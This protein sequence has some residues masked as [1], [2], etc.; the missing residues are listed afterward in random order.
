METILMGAMELLAAQGLKFTMDDLAKH[1]RMS[2]RTL[3]EKVGGKEHLLQLCMEEYFT[4]VKQL[5]QEILNEASTNGF[6][7]LK[8]LVV[9][10]PAMGK[11]LHISQLS[12]LKDTYPVLYEEVVYRVDHDWNATYDLLDEAIAQK[13]VR[14]INKD[15]F[16][17]MVVGTIEQ[18]LVHELPKEYDNFDLALHACMDLLFEGL[19]GEAYEK[20]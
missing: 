1:L 11:N 17:L 12:G 18:L 3:Y 4:Q 16:R 10:Q 9:C 8:Q 15:L 14:P 6:E 13:S 2:K 19:K 5:E 20:V 7:K